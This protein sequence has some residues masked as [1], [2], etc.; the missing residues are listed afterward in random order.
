[1]KAVFSLV[2]IFTGFFA[3]DVI[4]A[5]TIVPRQRPQDSDEAVLAHF[6]RSGNCFYYFTERVNDEKSL[7]PCKVFC[8]EKEGSD[9]YG[10]DA[11]AFGD[12]DF[13]KLD[14]KED[15][16][17]NP[18][19]I[20]NCV[21]SVPI[22][23]ELLR[24]VA[25]G[26]AK[27]DE[28]LCVMMLEALNTVLEFGIA[29]IPSG[30][31]ARAAVQAA[32]TFAENGLE[33]SSFFG[34]WVG[35]ACG[36]SDWNF[37]LFSALLQ[38]PDSIGVS[39]G[40]RRKN[41]ADCKKLDPVPDPPKRSKPTSKPT[42]TKATSTNDK[43]D[44]KDPGKATTTTRTTTTPSDSIGQT[45]AKS[46]ESTGKTNSKETISS[47]TSDACKLS[48]RA[49]PPETRRG[50]FGED[51]RSEEC[52][53]NVKTVHITK[54]DTKNVGVSE[55]SPADY[56]IILNKF[57]S[58]VM[59]IHHNTR[60]M[61]DVIPVII[62]ADLDPQVD[63]TQPNPKV[64]PQYRGKDGTA[65][66]ISSVSVLTARA[67]FKFID[68]DGLPKDDQW[69][70]LKDNKCWP[71]ELAPEDPGW[72]LLTNDEFYQAGQHPDLQVHTQS[73]R[74]LPDLALVKQALATNK[75]KPPYPFAKVEKVKLG[76]GEGQVDAKYFGILPG[77]PK[78]VRTR[79]FARVL[80]R[81]GTD[82]AEDADDHSTFNDE[83]AQTDDYLDGDLSDYSDEDLNRWIEEY[84][85]LMERYYPDQDS[86]DV[87]PTTYAQQTPE[88][89][90]EPT[91]VPA[92]QGSLATAK[93]PAVT[94]AI[95]SDI[96][97]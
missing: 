35:P 75:D 97:A 63:L 71:K 50:K 62:N 84:I 20:A 41:K 23:E 11:S 13:H 56:S 85:K 53:N 93:V 73:Y 32:K 54:T 81:N 8:R 92:I 15:D 47:V 16:D 30:A 6:E 55:M 51:E 72:A 80:R 10:C 4:S 29:A 17:G 61:T 49:P 46:T 48:K 70:G 7:A 78:N 58:S 77:V 65:T 22:A 14:Y 60:D 40:C 68:W 18:F 42:A 36:V 87:P 27:L 12:V 33:A 2:W 1:M 88:G 82:P 89:Q 28:V 95:M 76:N 86:D 31:G 26:L 64:D 24:V 59:D 25:E 43:I 96:M 79:R 52:N 44:T 19:V 74:G 91:T 21:C 39:T 94:K 5:R 69:Y 3:E 37:D 57:G 9:N 90:G 45:S 34:G 38:G 83:M 66:I 67:I